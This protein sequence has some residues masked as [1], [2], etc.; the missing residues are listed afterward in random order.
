MYFLI[1]CSAAYSTDYVLSSPSCLS[2]LTSADWLTADLWPHRG[3]LCFEA[4]FLLGPALTDWILLSKTILYEYD[5]L[6]L[7]RGIG[8]L[9]VSQ[10][11]SI[12]LDCDISSLP[13]RIQLLAFVR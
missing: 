12:R 2:R 10:T 11:T 5:E 4:L 3:A 7:L 13:L 1:G 6:S 9:S 8:R